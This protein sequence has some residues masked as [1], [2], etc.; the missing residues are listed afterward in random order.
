[1]NESNILIPNQFTFLTKLGAMCEAG[2]DKLHIVSDFD[3]TITKCYDEGGNKVPATIGLARHYKVLEPEYA[4]KGYE[5][6][7]IYHP[8]EIDESLTMDERSGIMDEWWRKHLDLMITYKFNVETLNKVIDMHTPN[9]RDC[10]SK[11]IELVDANDLPL[12]VFSAGIGN[13]IEAYFKQ[14]NFL[15]DN[16][17]IISN[18]LEFDEKTG[19]TIGYQS[20]IIHTFN[21]NESHIENYYFNDKF[22]DRRNIILIGDSTGDS[23]MNSGTDSDN[24]IKVGFFN[25]DK[26]EEGFDENLAKYLEIFDL[27]ILDDGS[28]EPINNILESIIKQDVSHL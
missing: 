14:F 5:L 8:Q 2:V 20:D 19:A 10:F 22:D 28:F 24:V 13:Y 26:T 17:H 9:I 16:V 18:F 6:F 21:K 27:I 3:R 4:K 15:K 1:M 11:F 25:M 7:D 23:Q 12:V